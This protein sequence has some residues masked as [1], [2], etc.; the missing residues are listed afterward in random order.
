LQKLFLVVVICKMLQ[1]LDFF[2]ADKKELHNQMRILNFATSA[3]KTYERLQI[4]YWDCE[5]TWLDSRIVG[6]RQRTVLSIF[7]FIAEQIPP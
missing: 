7:C 6:M 1:D 2:C 4:S 5:F 3:C